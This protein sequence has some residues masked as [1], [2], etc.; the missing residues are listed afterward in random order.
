MCASNRSLD[1]FEHNRTISC[2]ECTEVSGEQS[3]ELLIRNF[4]Y[5]SVLNIDVCNEALFNAQF[6]CVCRLKLNAE[7]NRLQRDTLPHTF[8]MMSQNRF[9]KSKKPTFL[10]GF[11]IFQLIATESILKIS[12]F[13][14]NLSNADSVLVNTVDFYQFYSKLINSFASIFHS[15]NPNESWKFP[16]RRKLNG[17]KALL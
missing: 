9:K 4:V 14:V 5:Y 16:L 10:S 11:Q 3:C 15:L 2:F 6:L 1:K 12:T 7:P 17:K 8:F 13:T